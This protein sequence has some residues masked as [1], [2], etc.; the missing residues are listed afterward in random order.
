MEGKKKKKRKR[1][2]DRS[3]LLLPHGEKK[4]ISIHHHFDLKL[5]ATTHLFRC[6][7][8]DST[9][10]P[11]DFLVLPGACELRLRS[12]ASPQLALVCAQASLADPAWI[13]ERLST[14]MPRLLLPLRRGNRLFALLRMPSSTSIRHLTHLRRRLPIIRKAI[15]PL[16][17]RS[18]GIIILPLSLVRLRVVHLHSAPSRL[19]TK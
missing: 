17:H 14:M 13:C 11:S 7:I 8:I 18:S 10:T 19:R 6:A 3:H 9:S 12:C 4:H 2:K 16:C 5:I 15:L 1:A